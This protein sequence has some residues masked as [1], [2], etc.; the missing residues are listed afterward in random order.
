MDCSSLLSSKGQV[1]CSRN[2]L[3]HMTEL[4]ISLRG[5]TVASR[6]SWLKMIINIAHTEKAPSCTDLVT[7]KVTQYA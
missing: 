5:P 6:L 2:S 4:Q 7:I 1:E 3:D